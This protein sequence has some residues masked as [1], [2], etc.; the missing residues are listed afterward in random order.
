MPWFNYPNDYRAIQERNNEDVP[1]EP[2]CEEQE[3]ESNGK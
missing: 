1:T 2:A 3:S